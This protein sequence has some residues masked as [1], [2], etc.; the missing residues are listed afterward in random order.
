MVPISRTSIILW[1][2]YPWGSLSVGRIWRASALQGD[3][4]V[5]CERPDCV[6]DEEC[7]SWLACIDQ[8]CEDP[9][10]CGPNADCRVVNHRPQCLCRPGY[11]G[12]GFVECTLSEYLAGRPL[13]VIGCFLRDFSSLQIISCHCLF[14]LD[15]ERS[16]RPWFS[17]TILLSLPP[18]P[19]GEPSFKECQTDG[20][21]PSKM[22]CFDGR[23]DDPCL[24]VKPCG[25]N[26]KC[27]VIDT[28]PYRTMTC[29][30][31]PGFIGNAYVECSP[32]KGNTSRSWSAVWLPD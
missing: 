1:L 2:L 17:L 3:P 7:P 22:A 12:N 14:C 30:C 29:E 6:V 10:N 5:R 18:G 19:V 21:C 24:V 16:C 20:D 8:E 11:E 23:C 15:P 25:V 27:E 13:I 9:C 28:L 26:A 32:R 4:Y 31:L